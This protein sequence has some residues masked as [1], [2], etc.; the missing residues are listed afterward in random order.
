MADM[1]MFT[2]ASVPMADTDLS[3]LD[4]WVHFF[5]NKDE[6]ATGNVTPEGRRRPDD[7]LIARMGPFEVAESA[8]DSTMTT[9][10]SKDCPASP[11]CEHESR[12]ECPQVGV[13]PDDRRKVIVTPDSAKVERE[14]LPHFMNRQSATMPDFYKGYGME[15][16]ATIKVF[17]SRLATPEQAS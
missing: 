3:Y 7:R 17:L 12:Q 5:P 15:E 4:L 1:S 8:G 10:R 9:R 13:D 11:H 14:L 6:A 16:L 2:R